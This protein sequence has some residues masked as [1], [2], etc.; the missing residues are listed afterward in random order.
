MSGIGESRTAFW[1]LLLQKRGID[2]PRLFEESVVGGIRH[3]RESAC[4]TTVPVE[5]DP[6][7]N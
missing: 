5:L 4:L 1:H 3:A 6:D 7:N 2:G